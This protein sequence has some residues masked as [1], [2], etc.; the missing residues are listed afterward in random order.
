MLL[1]TLKLLG[2]IPEEV[3]HECDCGGLLSTNYVKNDYNLNSSLS[4]IKCASIKCRVYESYKVD[5]ALKILNLNL[6]IGP[7]RANTLLSI[8][9]INN[10]MDIFGISDFIKAHTYGKTYTEFVFKLRKLKE[11]NKLIVTLPEFIELHCFP[12]LGKTKSQDIFCDFETP[13]V[14]FNKME[15]RETLARHISEKLNI[16]I[17]SDTVM[18][19]T[20]LLIREKSEIIRVS[21]YF[22]FKKVG[23]KTY[24]VIITGEITQLRNEQGNLF[25]PRESIKEYFLNK[26]KV[27]LNIG[28]SGSSKID[29]LIS[30]NPNSNSSKMKK[31]PKDKIVT[32]LQFEEIVKR[33]LNLP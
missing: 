8:Y 14:F 3:P 12:D 16:D 19:I 28:S 21:G 25:K 15:D 24:K 4:R 29:Y 2:V 31:T 5:K 18:S 26:Y 32:S 17:Y 13:E 30:D 6:N 20:S 9:N 27:T 23:Q 22:T 10:H 33:D 7:N 1:L 11:E